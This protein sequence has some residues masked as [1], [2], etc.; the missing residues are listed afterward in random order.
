MSCLKL[1]S[2]I[3]VPLLAADFALLAPR[4]G[5]EEGLQNELDYAAVILKEPQCLVNL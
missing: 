5:S 4:E 3:L 1:F 2:G